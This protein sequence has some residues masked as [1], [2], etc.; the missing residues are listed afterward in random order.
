MCICLQRAHALYASLSG[1]LEQSCTRSSK[2]RSRSSGA[3]SIMSLN[4]IFY[5]WNFNLLGDWFMNEYEFL[6]ATL[7][8]IMKGR[9][10]Q[11]F[12]W[13][14]V[15]MCKCY[16]VTFRYR[17]KIA[18]FGCLQRNVLRQRRFGKG[19]VGTRHFGAYNVVCAYDECLI[20]TYPDHTSKGL[21][22]TPIVE[23]IFLVWVWTK[24]PPIQVYDP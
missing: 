21:H 23:F 10:R 6:M 11:F 13:W 24:S 1:G 2:C 17:H 18:L 4:I 14:T 20:D 3:S 9:V 19:N 7:M 15:D 12:L 5:C 22:L 16:D 8:K